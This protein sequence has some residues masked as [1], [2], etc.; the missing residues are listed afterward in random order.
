MKKIIRIKGMHCKSCT[1]KIEENLAGLKGVKS[2]KVNLIEETADIAY[3]DKKIK[4]DKIKKEIIDLGYKIEGKESKKR[5]FFEA[6]AYGLLPH[7]GCIAFVLGSIFGATVLM[8]FF[9][10]L[11]MNRYFFY[12]LIGISF[13]F[14][15][16]SAYIYLRK[17]GFLSAFGLKR[18]WKYLAT[19]YGTTIGINLLLFLLIFPMLANVSSAS[20]G[21]ISADS[22]VL[23]SVRIPCPGHA[24]LIS[25]EL[26][27]IEGVGSIKYSLP[28][29]FEV[30]YD[31]SK[32]SVE[33]MLELEVF[34]EYPA[35]I[36]DLEEELAKAESFSGCGVSPSCALNS[37][38]L[39]ETDK[40]GC[41][42]VD[43]S[44]GS[45]NFESGTGY[46]GGSCGNSGCGCRG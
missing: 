36:L 37:I 19:M 8:Q 18:K 41:L 39:S 12:Y 45:E 40:A 3:D 6:L 31:S 42:Q 13:L 21:D 22:T 43:G 11:L 15:T 35:T 26:K 9:K 17:E 4:L 44:C 5:G 2:V 20:A 33:E 38:A 34:N 46:C 14:A 24:P 10:P 27:S 16:I 32:T 29:R 7:V 28:S 25:E 23:F 30:S 1:V